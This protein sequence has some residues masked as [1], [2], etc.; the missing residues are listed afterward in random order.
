MRHID[1]NTNLEQLNMLKCVHFA[2]VIHQKWKNF[3]Y[4]KL[5][6]NS[7]ENT[8]GSGDNILDDISHKVQCTDTVIRDFHICLYG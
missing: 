1:V 7:H 6:I 4:Y 2:K 5:S 8:A 3:F